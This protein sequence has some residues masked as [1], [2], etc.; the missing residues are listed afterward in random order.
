MLLS[1]QWSIHDAFKIS[2]KRGEAAF[3]QGIRRPGRDPILNLHVVAIL[4]SSGM[5]Q[6]M[7]SDRIQR[8]FN[9]S[10]SKDA[11]VDYS[12]VSL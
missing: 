7:S 3:V 9:G 12:Q 11:V 6:D 4:I 8:C 2:A 10:K 1:I 5:P